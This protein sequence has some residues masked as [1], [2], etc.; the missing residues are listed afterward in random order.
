MEKNKKGLTGGG[1]EMKQVLFF[2]KQLHAYSGKVIYINQIG[3]ALMSLLEGVGIFLLI[4][5]ISFTGIVNLNSKNG[6]KIPI[7][8]DLPHMFT[9]TTGLLLILSFYVLLMIGQNVFQR[10][11]M[12]LNSKIQQGFL[13][14]L[15]EQTY[16]A[17]LESNWQF[18]IRK[19]KTDI[20]NLMIVEIGRVG[21]GTNTFLQFISSLVFTMIQIGIAFYISAWMTLFVLFFGFMLLIFARSFIRKNNELGKDTLKLSRAYLAGITDHFNGIKEIKSN[22][23]ETTHIN[24][25]ESMARKVEKNMIDLIRVKQSSQVVYKC[26]SS[27]LIAAFIFLSI[28]MFKSQ[29]TQLMLVIVIFSRLWPRI[30]TIQ[31]NLELISSYL[32]SFKALIHLQ[33]ECRDAKEIKCGDVQKFVKPIQLKND[34]ECVDVTF[35]YDHIEPT[36]ALKNI[37]LNIPANEMTAIVGRSGAGKS[38]LIDI[39]MG[40]NRPETGN[41][42]IDGEKLDDHNL[43]ALRQAISYVPQDPFLFNSSIK[44]NLLVVRSDATEEEIWKALE[45]SSAAEF[46]KKLPHSIDT[47]IGDRGIKLSGGERQRVVLARAILR[48]PSILVLDEAT[49]SLD[50]ENEAKIQE[51]IE[52]IRGS[53]T[54]IVIAHRLS[55]IRNAD[56]VIVLEQGKIVQKGGFVQLANEKKGV[57]S[58]LLSNQVGLSQ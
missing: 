40:L 55:T 49:S 20:T 7:L 28:Y 52:K 36:Y 43:L 19:R 2:M 3:M 58:H 51:A 48:K 9:P 47:V 46:V 10:Q 35:R 45:F 17:I 57:F 37:N 13:R 25:H 50:T 41:V 29:P 32:P 53:M 30:T 39:L 6:F 15:K 56:Q 44:E 5:L 38:T 18:F 26:A 22:S 33:N 42:L 31:S 27:I 23:L 12:I 21:I 16:K 14:Y 4:P 11:Q 8:S 34:I 24:W 1:K 54:I